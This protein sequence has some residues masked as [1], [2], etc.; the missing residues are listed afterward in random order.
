VAG[1][2]AI[3]LAGGFLQKSAL[4]AGDAV[5]VRFL[6][7][8]KHIERSDKFRIGLHAGLGVVFGRLALCLG[9]GVDAPTPSKFEG[10][11]VRLEPVRERPALERNGHD[12][13]R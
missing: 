7:V 11:V 9:V 2:D 3:S 6:P 4:P 13:G 12:I 8:E 10:D 1:V 5:D